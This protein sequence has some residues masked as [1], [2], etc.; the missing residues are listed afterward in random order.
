MGKEEV[1]PST[2]KKLGV[3]EQ[4]EGGGKRGCRSDPCATPR[5][6]LL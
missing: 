3:R 4:I 1:D 6:K 5:P 2:D